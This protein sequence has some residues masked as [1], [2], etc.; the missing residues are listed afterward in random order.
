[1]KRHPHNSTCRREKALTLVELMV[2]LALA[3]MLMAATLGSLRGL[4]QDRRATAGQTEAQWR[5]ESLR[6]LLEADL[7]MADEIGF[8]NGELTLH[9][10]RWIDGRSG[11]LDVLPCRVRYGVRTMDGR[12]WLCR[13][14]EALVPGAAGGLTCEL[15]GPEMVIA[16]VTAAGGDGLGGSPGG[17]LGSAAALSV[18]AVAGGQTAAWRLQRR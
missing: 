16:A 14:Q 17:N 12:S 1:M 10:L 11:R 9:T 4:S 2:C 7:E 18:Q 8:Q 15:V 5:L 13:R 3:A 6:Q